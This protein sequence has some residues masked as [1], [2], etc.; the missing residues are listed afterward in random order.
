MITDIV[1]HL[2]DML[3]LS[4]EEIP[5]FIDTFLVSL[6]DCCEQ[7]KTEVENPDFAAIRITTHTL[8]GFTANMGAED[9]LAAT[10]ELNAAAKIPD[11]ELCRKGIATILAL[12]EEYHR[13][14]GR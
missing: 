7:L 13:Q 9:L 3:E 4:D 2:K 10:K 6:D 1:K 12:R 5:E 14:A 8:S 11:A